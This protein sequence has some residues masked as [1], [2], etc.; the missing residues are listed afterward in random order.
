MPHVPQFAA[1]VWRF[2][3]QPF[4]ALASQSAKPALQVKPHATPLQL[5]VAF[6]GAAQGV[7]VV[8]HAV[9]SFETHAPAHA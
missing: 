9:T 2:T 3:S 1:S 4:A 7:H 6:A 5:A 8:P